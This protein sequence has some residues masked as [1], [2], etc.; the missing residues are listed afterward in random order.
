M[1]GKSMRISKF[2]NDNLKP[3]SISDNVRSIPSITDGFK[4]SQRKSVYG[5]LKHGDKPKIKLSQFAE[6]TSLLTH[7]KH[8]SLDGTVVKLAQN[9]PGSNNIN[10][11]EPEGQF[12]NIL[13]HSSAASRYIYTLKSKHFNEI[14]KKEDSIIYNHIDDDGDIGEPTTFYP[15]VPLWLIN[16]ARG[17]GTGHSTLILNRD[18]DN[19]KK[20]ILKIINDEKPMKKWLN[21]SYNNYDGETVYEDASFT[22]IG[23]YEI[24]NTTTI[25]IT[26]L[27]L[28]VELDKYKSH[29]IKL[30]NEGKI[31]DYESK[32]TS[33]GFLFNIK[34]KRDVTKYSHDKLIRF[35]KLS[36]KFSENITLWNFDGELQRYSNVEE[37]LKDWV[38]WRLDKYE[39]R[40]LK[41]IESLNDRKLWL[42]QRKLFVQLFNST[43]N[44]HTFKEDK[45][46]KYLIDNDILQ[47]YI[48]KLLSIQTR[49]LTLAG[50]KKLDKEI[51]EINENISLLELT[52]SK[53]MFINELK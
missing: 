31:T 13:S 24:T 22:T 25:K 10:L 11:F 26:S 15:I 33:S 30:L 29:L 5:M 1:V 51:D 53:E 40:R 2:I 39:L 18:Y 7:Y 43:S 52:T 21:P 41:Q 45:L 37:P 27:P 49:S 14:I 8:G 3:Y 48:D 19:I 32:S 38:S 35:F 46:E 42:S 23:K 50:I 12:G 4:D 28:N 44:I 16:G 17:I 47:K 6:Q 9:F 20:A 36:R 34:V